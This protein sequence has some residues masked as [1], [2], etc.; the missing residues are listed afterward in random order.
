MQLFPLRRAGLLTKRWRVKGSNRRAVKDVSC[1]DPTTG[2]E[3]GMCSDEVALSPPA[4]S[5][6]TPR[7]HLSQSLLPWPFCGYFFSVVCLSTWQATVLRSAVEDGAGGEEMQKRV[8][9]VDS[10]WYKR[11]ERGRLDA[12][13]YRNGGW[14]LELWMDA[15]KLEVLFWKYTGREI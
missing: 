6:V 12:F 5:M 15:L 13:G 14:R 7:T 8:M 1:Q 11:G 9:S 4:P 3:W 10:S 2:P